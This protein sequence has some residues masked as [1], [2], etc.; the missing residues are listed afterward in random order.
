MK[1]R[2]TLPHQQRRAR[3]P[4][5]D[6][7][8]RRSSNRVIAGVATG[9]ADYIDAD[10]MTVRWVFAISIFFTAGISIMI[11]LLLWLML[12]KQPA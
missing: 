6:K 5:T 1:D 12:V 4:Q 9:I 7:L 3:R 8:L 2:N 10:P 11:Y